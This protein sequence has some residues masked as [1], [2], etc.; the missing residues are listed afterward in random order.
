[1]H[2]RDERQRLEA[3]HRLGQSPI[4]KQIALEAE[5]AAVRIA[6]ADYIDHPALFSAAE[7]FLRSI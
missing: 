5:S 1:M 6:A 2:C 4:L 3:A 7:V